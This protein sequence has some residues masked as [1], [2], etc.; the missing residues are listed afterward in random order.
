M[1]ISM[2]SFFYGVPTL[3]KPACLANLKGDL[4]SLI[5]HA[6]IHALGVPPPPKLPSLPSL[7]AL[8]PRTPPRY[9]F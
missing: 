6:G 9:L 4:Q 3:P 8:H 7:L 1:P 5:G 2:P